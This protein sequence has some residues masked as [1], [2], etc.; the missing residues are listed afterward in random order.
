MTIRKLAFIS[1]EQI[2]QLANLIAKQKGGAGQQF[3]DTVTALND[4]GKTAELSSYFAAETASLLLL[5]ESESVMNLVIALLCGISDTTQLDKALDLVLK[6]FSK[7]DPKQASTHL[8]ILS[9]MYNSLESTSYGRFKTYKTIV[10]V[11]SAGDELDAV[12]DTLTYLEDWI[13]EWQLTLVDRRA[14]YLLLSVELGKSESCLIQAQSCLLRYLNT[15]QGLTKEVN[16]E[17]INTLAVKALVQAISIPEVLNFEDVLSL[18]AVQALGSTKIF[19]LAKIFLDQSLTKYK[20]FVTKNPKFVREQGLSQDANIRKMRI[21]SLATLATEHL[22]GEVSYS[23]I[24]KA[25]DV[26]E[27]D[28]E[29]WVIDGEF[30]SSI[31]QLKAMFMF[32]YID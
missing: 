19:E 16:T 14:L 22:Q 29:F 12:V 9:T 30:C 18:T 11:A 7:V 8:A 4:A 15:Y 5:A 21:L 17:S 24:S 10:Q 27:D 20:A 32:V 25:L 3:V 13:S 28:V 1:S 31:D 26:S 2:L 6:G 23:T